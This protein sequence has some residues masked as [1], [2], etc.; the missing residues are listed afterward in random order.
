MIHS[1]KNSSAL[2]D[3]L[4]VWSG[5]K[6][7]RLLGTNSWGRTAVVGVALVVVAALLS[8]SAQAIFVLAVAAVATATVH[9]VTCRRVSDPRPWRWFVVAGTLFVAGNAILLVWKAATGAGAPLPS[10]ADPFFLLGYGSLLTGVVLLVRRRSSHANGDNVMDAL[11]ATTVVGV[12]LWAF[13]LTPVLTGS[14][15]TTSQRALEVAYSAFDLAVIAG[16]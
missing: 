4:S 14:G 11:M 13:V 10:V 2:A 15:L 3:N 5:G 16:A 7:L 6:G 1:Y 12:A 9:L 8:P